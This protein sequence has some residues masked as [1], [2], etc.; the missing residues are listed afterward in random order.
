MRNYVFASFAL[1]LAS[2]ATAQAQQG[3]AKVGNVGALVV[4]AI[5]AGD[6][7]SDL[8]I[9]HRNYQHDP[10]RVASL[11][12]C[13]Y[14]VL[15]GTRPHVLHLDWRCPEVENSTFTRIYLPEGKLSRLE[16]QPSI[17]LMTPTGVGLASSQLPPK[18]RIHEQF[19]DAVISGSDPS[20]GG[21]LPISSEHRQQLAT[22][23][24]W[25][26]FRED[27]SGEYGAETLWLDQ[28]RNPS[29]GAD[30]TIHFDDAGRPI[31][32]W[33]RTSSIRTSVTT[34]SNQ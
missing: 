13:D 27:A 30:T 5:Q 17:A 9:F 32:L 29:G 34:S 20:L 16:F 33:L 7:L 11:R 4:A 12:G 28:K 22:M 3:E 18:K 25:S 21:L 31:G 14:T 24:G 8:G 15:P 6:N 2:C 1:C 23:R 10:T 19:Q 26:V